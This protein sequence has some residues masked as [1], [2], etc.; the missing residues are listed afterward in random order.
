M[1]KIQIG[2]SNIAYRIIGKGKINIIIE[3]SINSC[4]AEWWN[5][6]EKLA[7]KYTFLVY[8]RAGYGES[9]KSTL[10]RTPENI[11]SELESLIKSLNLDNQI[12]LIGH[13]Q[14]GLYAELFAIRNQSL[15]KGLLLLDPLS[16]KDSLFQEKLT[17]DEY[18]KSGV[19]KSMSFKI[20]KAVTRFGL[21]FLF[22]GMLKKAP[23][24]YYYHFSKE[25]ED[26][27][28]KSLQ[29]Y[30]QYE[31]ALN[32][33]IFSH[34]E[35]NLSSFINMKEKI[36]IPVVLIT[37]SPQKMIA[38][39]EY[40]GNTSNELAKKVDDLWQHIMEQMMYLST[41]NKKVTA[42]NSSHYIHLTDFDLVKEELE[43]LFI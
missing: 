38:E 32:E 15:V 20:G 5:F 29:K 11:V 3:G 25:S 40:Y 22:K 26:Y 6:C 4:N 31:T 9:S 14:G 43:Q 41:N 35:G 7:D 23:P 12:I 18:K 13:S 33:Y 2:T 34:N 1:E 42:E 10:A 16:Y 37:H 27:I 39:I 28:L 21:G 8:D 24:F 30:S 17:A 19:D 36:N